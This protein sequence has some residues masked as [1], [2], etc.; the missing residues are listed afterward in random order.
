[1]LQGAIFFLIF[2]FMGFIREFTAKLKI[3]C[4]KNY[5]K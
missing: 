1:M 2:E 5:L 4:L 3:F